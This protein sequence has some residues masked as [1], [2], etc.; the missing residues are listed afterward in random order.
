MTNEIE[1]L[2]SLEPSEVLTNRTRRY[3]LRYAIILL[4]KSLADAAIAILEKDFE[5]SP[6]SYADAFL[7]LAEKGVID[8]ST[9]KKMS[10]LASLRNIIVHRYWVIDDTKILSEARESGVEAVNKFID[11]V[12]KYVETEDP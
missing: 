10:K 9:A 3:S 11:E 12:K 2:C 1:S 8:F 5:V 7:K 4:V 6:H